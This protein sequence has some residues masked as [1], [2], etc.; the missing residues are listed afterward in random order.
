[1]SIVLCQHL[2]GY[3]Q[4]IQ[5]SAEAGTIILRLQMRKLRLTYM[6]SLA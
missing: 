3:P 4:L 2:Q 5:Q 6:K 1:M